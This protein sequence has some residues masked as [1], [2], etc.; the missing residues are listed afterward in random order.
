M[1][2]RFKRPTK[3]MLVTDV[4]VDGPL[5]DNV[6]LFTWTERNPQSISSGDP[7]TFRA[8]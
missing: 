6:G 8:G 5:D 3:M 4:L 2:R 1:E 7:P